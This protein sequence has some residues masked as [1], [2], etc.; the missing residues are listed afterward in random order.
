MS[1]RT[2]ILVV[3]NYDS[4][5]YNI[6][7]YLQELGADV[8]VYRNDDVSVADLVDTAYDGVLISPGPGHPRDAG[9]C[10]DI[11][12]HCADVSLPMLGVCLG[13]Q[14]LGEAL[15]A[16][17]VKAPELFHG[18]S[19]AVSHEH[20]GVFA[21]VAQPVTAGRY[22]SLVV[23]ADSLPATLEVT[24][25]CGELIMGMRH[26]TLP[27]EGVQF[28]PESVLTQD[29][30]LMLANWLETCGL[31][32]ARERANALSTRMDRIRHAL[33]APGR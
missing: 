11:I 3:D 6:V 1:P 33:P 15:G 7:Q 19:S 32:G 31:V 22:H 25:T 16:N 27:L 12:R 17:V 5:V 28:H 14:A 13:H 9:N 8:S 30:Y 29:G 10:L 24:A 26:R 4:F 2:S 20:Q 23:D 18:R 21:G